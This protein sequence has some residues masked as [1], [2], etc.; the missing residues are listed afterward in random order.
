MVMMANSLNLP[1]NGITITNLSATK[2][3]SLSYSPRT[4]AK[5]S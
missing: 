5:I 4:T 1:F 2:Q 3:K